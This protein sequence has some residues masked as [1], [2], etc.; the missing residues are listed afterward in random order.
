VGSVASVRCAEVAH[1]CARMFVL[2]ETSQSSASVFANSTKTR[3]S[4]DYRHGQYVYLIPCLYHVFSQSDCMRVV[5]SSR[6]CESC[7]I[8]QAFVDAFAS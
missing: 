7:M 2:L 8:E 3:W 1:A 4:L 6:M 5:Y